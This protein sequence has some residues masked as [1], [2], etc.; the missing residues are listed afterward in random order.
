MINTFRCPD[1]EELF[2]R[3]RTSRFAAI[4]PV[5]LRRLAILNRVVRVEELRIP[6]G[7]RLESLRGGR[8]G[9]WSIRV[10]DQFR[11]CFRFEHGDAYDVE[12]VD[13]H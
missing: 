11:I 2:V 1:T 5:A 6:P 7:N 13:S 8:R 9:T 12:I 4:A 10:N 3:L